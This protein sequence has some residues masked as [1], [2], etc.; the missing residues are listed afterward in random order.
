MICNNC[1]S[2]KSEIIGQLNTFNIFKCIVCDLEILDF[3]IEQIAASAT[4]DSAVTSEDYILRNISTFK[5]REHLFSLLA[6]NQSNFFQKLIGNE[7]DGLKILEIGCGTA[8]R[9]E[10]FIK[11]GHSYLGIDLEPRFVDFCNSR[12][13][14]ALKC[15]FKDFN[16]TNFDIIICSQVLEHIKNLPVFISK[17]NKLLNAQG[18]FIVDLPNNKS[19]VSDILRIVKL[20]KNRYGA[21]EHPHHLYGHCSKSLRKLL[22]NQFNSIDIT[23][24]MPDHNLFGQATK[25]PWYWIPIKLVSQ[26]TKKG[27]LLVGIAR[28]G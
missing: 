8:G 21:I 17:I 15:D 2:K 9:A 25:L 7:K 16:E 11:N 24:V 23:T 28:K 27:S 22:E 6:T 19:I 20:K 26:I 3:Q 4:S 14:V 18:V 10:G 12:G 1:G 13:I 5:N